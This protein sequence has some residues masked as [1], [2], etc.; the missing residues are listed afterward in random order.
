MTRSINLK[1]C[2]TCSDIMFYKVIFFRRELWK[3]EVVWKN[4]VKARARALTWAGHV[5]QSFF[6]SSKFSWCLFLKLDSNTEKSYYC[7]ICC[8]KYAEEKKVE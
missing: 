5:F 4:V 1:N 7:D 6:E 3:P 2:M 8:A